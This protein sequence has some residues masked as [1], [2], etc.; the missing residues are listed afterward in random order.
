MN[1]IE[2]IIKTR[3]EH[4][5]G[6]FGYDSR[7]NYEDAAIEMTLLTVWISLLLELS[8]VFFPSCLY[9]ILV[10]IASNRS[11]NWVYRIKLD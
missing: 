10:A 5:D 6:N 9:M 7:K 2:K 1:I 3:S 4:Q 8:L 11:T